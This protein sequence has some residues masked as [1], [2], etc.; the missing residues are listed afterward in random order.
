[1]KRRTWAVGLVVA[2][3]AVA[4]QQA[5]LPARVLAQAPARQPAP[6]T[7]AQLPNGLQVY[8]Y[9]D[10]SVPVAAVSVWYR[11]GSK[12]EPPGRRGMA[13]LLEH[14]M[15][16]G[17]RHVP[18]EE[19]ARLIQRMGGISNAFTSS[20]VTVYWQKLP[21]SQ[22]ELA[23]WLE[24]ERMANLVLTQEKLAT[25]RE[26]VKEEFRQALQNN[27]I[28]LAIDRFHAWMFEGTPY[29]WTPAGAIE[30][31]DAV[32]LEDLE[33]FYRTYYVPAN[34]VLVVAGD[35]QAEQVLELARR[36]FGPL[37][38]GLAP[39]RP[40]VLFS[41]PRTA[42]GATAVR[43]LAFP[44]QLPG[45]LG[46]YAIPGASHPDRFALEVAEQV[47]AGG[48]SSRL[49]R[50]LVREQQVAVF[51]EAGAVTY[52]KAGSFFLLGFFLPERASAGQLLQALQQEASRLADEPPSAAELERAKSRLAARRAFALE[53]ADEVAR[54]LG[55][56]V[57]LEG[58]LE[59]F[60][61]GV[62]PY[63]AVTA[64][65]VAGVARRYFRPDNF[66]AVVIE[67]QASHATP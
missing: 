39:P 2:V 64:E 54:A 57:V 62:E 33:S 29:A 59:H 4:W 7:R 20:D 17:S 3:W 52:E 51:A 6:V 43:S 40:Q 25:E 56:A 41:A 16:K 49:H 1:M 32:R 55:S 21:A 35:V 12:D 67:P 46:G 34:A 50:R 36:H 10:H 23:L 28:G 31:L 14:L 9:E 30:D 61:A 13:H 53:S 65:E 48:D 18:P 8:V 24:A 37:P 27:P 47:L 58:G 5:E 15:F 38:P 22:L 44:V 66:T 42:A 63:L 19:H 45:V 11:V 26:V 60:L